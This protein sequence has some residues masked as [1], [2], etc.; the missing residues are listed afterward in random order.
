MDRFDGPMAST[1]GLQLG[2]VQFGGGAAAQDDFGFFGDLEG[3]EM[4]GG[5]QDDGGLDGVR[6]T[7]L[8]RSDLKRVDLTRLMAAMA[9]VKRDVRREKKRPLAP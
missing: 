5:A 8:R 4:M 1:Q 9:L 6:E 2:C 3:L 7:R